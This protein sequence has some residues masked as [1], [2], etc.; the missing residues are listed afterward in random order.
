MRNSWGLQ[1]QSI[2]ASSTRFRTAQ[3][4][5]L[6]PHHFRVSFCFEMKTLHVEL[7]LSRP[8]VPQLDSFPSLVAQRHFVT[9]CLSSSCVFLCC[10]CVLSIW[11]CFLHFVLLHA[12]RFQKIPFW[13][14]LFSLNTIIF[15]YPLLICV[16]LIQLFSLPINTLKVIYSFYSSGTFHL[17]LWKILQWTVLYIFLSTWDRKLF[18]KLKKDDLVKGTV[19]HI[20]VYNVNFSKLVKS[21]LYLRP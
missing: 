2:P 18:C 14:F 11:G 1:T 3:F 15:R 13:N 4:C 5:H 16:A 21:G 8:S 20:C 9:R 12:K 7:K 6:A 10:Y 17:L 19:R